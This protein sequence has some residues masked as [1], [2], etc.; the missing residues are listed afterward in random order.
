[1]TIILCGVNPDTRFG[2]MIADD[3]QV[4][5]G[6]HERR[7]CDKVH[8]INNRFGVAG[9]GLATGPEA[10]SI[11]T[12]FPDGIEMR[13]GAVWERPS[14]LHDLV[15][16][17]HQLIQ[18]LANLQVIGVSELPDEQIEF[19]KTQ[20][21]NLVVLDCATCEMALCEFGDV[22]NQSASPPTMT[23][24]LPHRVY[25]FGARPSGS[26]RIYS[27]V[28]LSSEIEAFPWE[29]A[30]PFIDKVRADSGGAVGDCGAGIVSRAGVHTYRTSFDSPQDFADAVWT[31]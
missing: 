12:Q 18:R 4:R 27:P 31:T 24:L 14:N 17:I 7:R 20:A 26:P 3:L 8:L 2:F 28:S 23:P 22:I 25:Q 9:F 5:A 30:Q 21:C 29:W 15:G 1:M 11:L 19:L 6:D 13:G 10:A 16:V